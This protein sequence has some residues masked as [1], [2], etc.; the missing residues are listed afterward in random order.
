MEKIVRIQYLVLETAYFSNIKFSES[1]LWIYSGKKWPESG[2]NVLF[3][4]IRS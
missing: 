4:K 3:Q 2:V 1:C